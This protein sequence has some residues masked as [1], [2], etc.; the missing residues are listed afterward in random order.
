MN[1]TDVMQNLT[2]D[3][4]KSLAKKAGVAQGLTRKGEVITELNRFV[5]TDVQRFLEKLSPTEKNLLS[6]AAH[7]RGRVQPSTFAAK[8]DEHCPRPGRWMSKRDTSLIHLVIAVDEETG[9]ILV[10]PEVVDA[11]S[12]LVPKPPAV[13]IQP[14]D[15]IPDVLDV[16]NEI[17]RAHV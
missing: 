15:E 9:E 6:E 16:T 14:V 11:V 17:G 3:V 1:A 13:T 8:Y 7:C 10:P 5:R 12:P 2:A 4:L